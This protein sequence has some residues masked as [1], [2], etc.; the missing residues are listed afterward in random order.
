LVEISFLKELFRM[1][2]EPIFGCLLAVAADD[3]PP[4]KSRL[5]SFSS[6]VKEEEDPKCFQAAV[7]A[8]NESEAPPTIRGNESDLLV[9][10]MLLV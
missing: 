4:P 1:L 10:L 3:P 6:C 7:E 8:T 5:S 9:R 2:R